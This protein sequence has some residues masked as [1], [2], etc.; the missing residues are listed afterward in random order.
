MELLLPEEWPRLR[1]VLLEQFGVKE[2]PD[3]ATAEVYASFEGDTPICFFIMERVTH[4]G[5]FYVHPVLRGRGLAR[6]MAQMAVELTEGQEVYISST[7]P[8][9][10][11][12]AESLGLVPVV[13]RLWCKEKTDVR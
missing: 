4:A 3:P 5:P 6:M 10:G 1:S 11:H 9:V 2:L 13:G 12:I 7:T 8:E